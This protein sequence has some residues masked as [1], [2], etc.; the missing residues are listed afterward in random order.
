[1]SL[2][3]ISSNKLEILARH[4]TREI[5]CRPL[6]DP[7]QPRFVVIQTRGMADWLRLQLAATTPI[8][9]NLEMPYL[10]NFVNRMMLAV[11]PQEL[12]TG[13]RRDAELFS[14]PVMAWRIHALL[15]E[16]P[17]R[18]PE[19]TGY[20]TGK[21]EDGELKRWQ[22][23]VRI[24]GLFDQYQIYR[25]DELVRWPELAALPRCDW[26]RRL[27][28]E[29]LRDGHGREYYFKRFF[30]L[31]SI[32][33]EAL[34]PEIA[35][36]GIG[37]MPPVFLEFIRKLS[38][39]CCV[40][41]FYLN[42][43][44][45]FW[46][47]QYSRREQRRLIARDGGSPEDFPGN[48]LL[49]DWGEQGRQFFRAVME[50][51]SDEFFL[52]EDEQEHFIQP[53]PENADY[54]NHTMLTA[55]QEDIFTLR[56]RS[57][58]AAAAD[59][60]LVGGPLPIPPGD[61]SIRIHNCHSR[62]R[63]VEVLHDQLLHLLSDGTIQPR[64]ILVMAPDIGLYEP[65]ITSI[66]EEGPLAG[67]YTISDRSIRAESRIAEAF[68]LL[69]RLPGSRFE[70]SR[71]LEFIDT[72]AVRKRF[73]IAEGDLDKIENWLRQSAIHWGFDA[74][75]RRRYCEVPFPEFSWSQGL[76]RLLLGFAMLVPGENDAVLPAGDAE[77]NDAVLLGNFISLV[78][79]IAD[80]ETSLDTVHSPAK[81]AELFR[82]ILD[83]FFLPDKESLEE[84]AALRN[85]IGG[86][87]R[88][89]R[90]A[91]AETPLPLA[92]MLDQL[93]GALENPLRSRTFL[94]GEITF[95][96]LVPMRSIPM[97]VIAI[98]GLNE[99]EFPR[100]ELKLGF[101]LLADHIRPCDRSRQAEDRYLFLEAILSA[102]EQLML[103]YDGQDA[104]TNES[105]PPAA[106]LA[107]LAGYLEKMCGYRE[108]R[109]KLQPFEPGYFV[110][111]APDADFISYSVDNCAAAGAFRERRILADQPDQTVLPALPE[112]ELPPVIPLEE[113]ERF[114]A[115]PPE[116][117]LRNRA[118]LNLFEDP[119]VPPDDE[120]LTLDALALYQLRNEIVPQ[121]LA[122]RSREVEFRRFNRSSRLP[123][124]EPGRQL[125]NSLWKEPETIP[126]D[127]HKL[128]L[129]PDF[130][131]LDLKIGSTRLTG[132]LRITPDAG[133][134][135]LFTCASL[136]HKYLVRLR[137]AQL[138]LAAQSTGNVPAE[139]ELL[140]LKKQQFDI[141][142]LPPVMPEQAREILVKLLEW[143]RRGLSRPLPVFERATPEFI[144]KKGSFEERIDA[145]RKKFITV[146]EYSTGDLGRR[147]VAIC[148][149]E[150]VFDNLVFQQEFAELAEL[151]YPEAVDI[152]A[153]ETI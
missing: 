86:M 144:R 150:N 137:L 28:L 31:D 42:P 3:V 17:E 80:L 129:E 117:F 126:A 148:F 19:L 41:L 63:E 50:L 53:P 124:G 82:G 38:E 127:W 73:G 18:F 93:D 151:L 107:E 85:A 43:C 98:L 24:A 149:A 66:F 4:F 58:D 100:Q 67:K 48:P 125:F 143:F 135:L 51:P 106:P 15:A 153:E 49:A 21:Q 152:T 1:M 132:K 109:H 77:G 120:P 55:L 128:I 105:K 118:G 20:F 92:V 36:F 2:H 75:T 72:P 103:F 102:R 110:P 145:A 146:S 101:N 60:D 133:T 68:L 47:H 78:R 40:D 69:L 23:S 30:E 76:D 113:L 83:M 91:R 35:V 33:P 84:L 81:W 88:A 64:D 13:F 7:M 94:R 56:D 14:A 95:A 22:L 12:R 32:A 99:S 65:C 112:T 147:A 26:Q 140:F 37:A 116:W 96:S 134:A 108:T 104:H 130:L 111:G 52:P 11:F 59:G 121:Q 142:K 61:R 57:A 25:Y 16:Q 5:Y 27:Y 115:D 71:L 9:A 74:E 46:E 87:E 136:R 114:F 123:L 122:G 90:I 79:R 6:P 70:V 131:P 29:L 97:K 45:E 139:A 141:H 39:S 138:A 44:C 119:P 34:P 54:R 8:A 10:N 62:R 89:A